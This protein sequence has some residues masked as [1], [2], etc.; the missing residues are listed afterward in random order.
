MRLRQS[1][2]LVSASN[3]GR[4][5]LGAQ[6]MRILYCRTCVGLVGPSFALVTLVVM[7]VMAVVAVM[8]VM[9]GVEAAEVSLAEPLAQEHQRV[10]PLLKRYCQECHAGDVIEGDV[11]LSAA[12]S[13]AGVRSQVKVWQ[14]V[15]EMVGSRQMPPPEAAQPGDAERAEI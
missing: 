13:L 3:G 11:D 5:M 8:A 14:R 9:A 2:H 1:T 4:A 15:A 12:D 6:A 7:A 10:L